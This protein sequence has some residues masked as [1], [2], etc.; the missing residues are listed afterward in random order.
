MRDEIESELYPF[1][2]VKS[3]LPHWSYLMEVGNTA[4]KAPNRILVP[5]DRSIKGADGVLAIAQDLLGPEGEGILLHV[6]P[7][8]EAK[9]VGLRFVSAKQAEN[10]N[11][12][13]G[14]GF[15]KYFANRLNKVSGQWRCEVV[16]SRSVPEGIA[17]TAA[18]EEVDLIAM[19]THDRKG[20]ARMFKGSVTDKVKERAPTEVRV[21]R[22]YELVGT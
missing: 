10:E 15:M 12:S 7:P 14:M 11:R 3:A 22:P 18:R 2:E 21:V 17:D 13:L 20:L 8:G 16:V 5:L 19:Y 4:P 1:G 9:T 6:I